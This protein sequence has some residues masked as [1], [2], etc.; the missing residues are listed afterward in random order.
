VSFKPLNRE[1]GIEVHTT[2]HET[3]PPLSSS[4][5]P[6]SDNPI[7]AVSDWN[8]LR[9]ADLVHQL[10]RWGAELPRAVGLN[11]GG[12]IESYCSSSTA[13]VEVVKLLTSSLY[14]AGRWINL[15][16]E[17][18]AVVSKPKFPGATFDERPIQPSLRYESGKKIFS[19]SRHDLLPSSERE[20]IDLRKVEH[21]REQTRN[22]TG[23]WNPLP[24]FSFSSIKPRIHK[25]YNS[26]LI[27]Q[28]N[29]CVLLLFFRNFLQFLWTAKLG[30]FY[31]I[32]AFMH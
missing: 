25:N 30:H 1:G 27:L 13:P 8:L 24:Y 3:F 23:L 28:K 19:P 32:E 22:A 20:H 26:L 12:W 5:T 15:L 4:P 11:S 9:A 14:A 29:Y 16:H 31:E 17:A 10:S 6:L 18:C 7:Y 21:V 2:L